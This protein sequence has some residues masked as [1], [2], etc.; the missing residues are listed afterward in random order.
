MKNINSHVFNVRDTKLTIHLQNENEKSNFQQK[1]TDFLLKRD[2]LNKGVKAKPTQTYEL[3]KEDLEVQVSFFNRTY[4]EIEFFQSVH[5][6]HVSGPQYDSNKYDLMPYL[7]KQ[8]FKKEIRYIKE[9]LKDFGFMDRTESI[10]KTAIERIEQHNQRSFEPLEFF[11]SVPKD[12]NSKRNTDRNGKPIQIGEEKYFRNRGGRLQKGKVYYNNGNM[13]WVLLNKFDFTNVAD[14]E[15]FDITPEE[16]AVRKKE[17]KRKTNKYRIRSLEKVIELP[18]TVIRKSLVEKYLIHKN[19][20]WAEFFID[21]AYGTLT[22]RSSFGT[23]SYGWDS[24]GHDLKAFLLSIMDKEDG[25]YGYILGKLSKGEREFLFDETIKEMKSKILEE[26]REDEI[27]EEEA[28]EMWDEIEGLDECSTGNEFY[29]LVGNASTFLEHFGWEQ[30]GDMIREGT[31][32]KLLRL[33]EFFFPI[34]CEQFQKELNEKESKE[35]T[36]KISRR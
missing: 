13:W 2:F 28:R 20:N 25:Y 8:K 24:Y 34:I 33:A 22:I 7:I 3:I 1:I 14:H 26:R 6:K 32:N 5:T 29:H 17:D 9:W 16:I 30:V 21:E 12:Y 18:T 27:N 36:K 23:Y 31:P 19:G 4:I 35:A 11:D 15:L 10:K